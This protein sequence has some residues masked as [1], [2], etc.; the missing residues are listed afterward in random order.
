[1][2]RKPPAKSTDPLTAIMV[3]FGLD[4]AEWKI[5]FFFTKGAISCGRGVVVQVTHVPTTRVVVKQ[6]QRATT[7]K[8]AR[9]E[10]LPMVRDA[11]GSLRR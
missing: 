6:S 4:P 5:S 3:K 1:M 11:P 2:G 9:S 8:D 7:K 10:V